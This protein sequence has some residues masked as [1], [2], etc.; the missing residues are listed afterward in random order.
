MEIISDYEDGSPKKPTFKQVK[1]ARAMFKQ[2]GVKLNDLQGDDKEL[3]GA[4]AK[5]N[6]IWSVD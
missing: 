2:A 5:F 4:Y 6:H 3:R 1:E